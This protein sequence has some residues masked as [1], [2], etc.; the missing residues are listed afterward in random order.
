MKRNTLYG[1]MAVAL[2][3]IVPMV[4]ADITVSHDKIYADVDYAKFTSKNQETISVTTS[5]FTITNNGEEDATVSLLV[6]GLPAGYSSS[7]KEIT[8]AGNSTSDSLTLTLDI[9]HKKKPGEEKI[10]VVTLS[11]GE[12]VDLIQH[13]KSMLNLQKLT[14]EYTDNKGRTQKDSLNVGSSSVSDLDDPVQFGTE[15]TFIIELKN[16]FDDKYATKFSDLDEIELDINADD[17]LFEEDTDDE[18]KLK[19]LDAEE[20]R[21]E[22]VT[23]TISEDA[24]DDEYDVTF[25]IRAEDGKGIVHKATKTIGIEVKRLKDDV[26]ITKAET[27]PNDILLCDGRFIVDLQVKNFGT[28]DQKDVDITLVSSAL[29]INKKF[30]NVRIDDYKSSR[31]VWRELLQFELEKNVAV[32]EQYLDVTVMVNGKSADFK[33]A[34]VSI[35]ECVASQEEVDTEKKDED[36]VTVVVIPEESGAV[37][38]PTGNVVKRVE[39][40]SRYAK[41]DLRLG[42]TI[43]LLVIVVAGLIWGVFTLARR[44]K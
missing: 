12:T 40:T 4:Y 2:L 30:E 15:I 43:A 17:D 8:I 3:L 27:S 14:V 24:D 1:L 32:S 25:T 28:R 35:K 22:V 10:G 9:P 19:D 42:G 26:R 18:I 6:A 36:K 7:S 38:S 41:D 37:G 31:S 33:R 21:K 5:A 23:L 39:T 44:R 13:T 11:N 34:P 16:L 29:G 20:K